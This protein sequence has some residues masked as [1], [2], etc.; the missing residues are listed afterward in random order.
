MS[1][2]TYEEALHSVTLAPSNYYDNILY[3]SKGWIKEHGYFT[4][5]IL[6]SAYESQTT[7]IPAEPRVYGAVVKDLQKEKMIQHSG[8]T[9]AQNKQA[10][11][12]PIS[13]WKVN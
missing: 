3:F 4:T 8:Y 7:L 13:L 9:T 1:V 5:E 2:Q 12:R 11:N 10:H 6:R